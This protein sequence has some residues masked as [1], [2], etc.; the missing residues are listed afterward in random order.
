VQLHG[1]ASAGVVAHDAESRKDQ[2]LLLL[3]LLL[4]LLGAAAV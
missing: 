2:V 3:L 1:C 4:L